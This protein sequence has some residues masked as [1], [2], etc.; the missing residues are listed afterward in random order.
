MDGAH[1]FMYFPCMAEMIEECN[2][3]DFP[4]SGDD[5]R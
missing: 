3:G 2:E 4:G 5:I 1:F